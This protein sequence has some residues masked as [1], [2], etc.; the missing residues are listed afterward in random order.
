MRGEPHRRFNPLR[1]EWVLVSPRRNERPWHGQVE[2]PPRPATVAYDPACYLCPGNTRAGGVRNPDYTATFAFNNDYPALSGQQSA[3]GSQ[4]SDG[5]PFFVSE[6]ERGVCRVICFSPRHDLTLARMDR[7]ALRAV[8]DRWIDECAAATEEPWIKYVLVFE[9]RG[10]MMGASNPHPHC[11]LWATEHVPSEPA[12]ERR[13]FDDYRDAHR[14]ACLLCDYLAGE[15]ERRER[16]VCENDAFVAVVPFWAVWPF[17]TLVLAR[18]HAPALESFDARERDAF[19]AILQRL[20]SQYD[21]LFDAPFPYSMG[22]HQAPTHDGGVDSWHLHAHFYPPL[23]RSATVRKFVV[24]FELLGEPQR[25]LTPEQ[26]AARL[27]EAAQ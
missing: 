18:R 2:A 16:I 3:V 6:P 20:T 21:A 19:A 17:E 24:G 25:D 27:R 11:Q 23:L 4:Q 7:P 22:I 13:A 1:Q 15:L 14:G 8:V 5:G 12:R 10:E 26:A 9:N